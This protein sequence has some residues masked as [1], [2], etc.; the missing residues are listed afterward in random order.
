MEIQ[1]DHCGVFNDMEDSI[2]I[3]GSRVV[4]KAQLDC[5]TRQR[6]HSK[7]I[8]TNLKNNYWRTMSVDNDQYHKKAKDLTA[9]DFNETFVYGKQPSGLIPAGPDQFYVVWFAKVLGNWKA[10]VSTD[11]INGQYWEITYNGAKRETYVDHY[12]KNSNQAISDEA[13]AVML[14]GVE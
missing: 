10:C 11:L 8:T 13:Y 2:V 12:V 1:C 6:L 14:T 7:E 3:S 4:C 9:L 5:K